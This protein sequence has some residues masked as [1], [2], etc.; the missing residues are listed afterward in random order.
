MPT[1]IAF[2]GQYTDDTG[3]MFFNARYYNPL[4]GR[5]ASAD[6]IVPGAGNPQ[7]LNRYAYTYNNPLRYT[8]STGHCIDPVTGTACAAA[9]FALGTLAVTAIYYAVTPPPPLPHIYNS[10]A[11]YV[12]PQTS[13]TLGE[14]VAYQAW[15]I[16]A[17]H[18]LSQQAE[19]I[20][21]KI[22][23]QED[24]RIRAAR[25]QQGGPPPNFQ[26]PSSNPENDP[27]VLRNLC[28]G[29]VGLALCGGAIIGLV[30]ALSQAETDECK[31]P[32][33]CGGLPDPTAT[34]TPT[35]TPTSTY[36]PT[37]TSTYTSTPTTTPTR[38]PSPTPYSTP[39]RIRYRGHYIDE[40]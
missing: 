1:K 29:K 36:M 9:L 24:Q 12:A 19:K 15:R 38:T 40:E 26:K 7:A 39:E 32:E 28:R 2:T 23:T 34:N 22:A 27:N 31:G 4:T 11:P 18:W 17:A 30:W 13:A 5:F 35:H 37:P 14:T 20:A 21:K 8:D 25:K 33:S 10:P 16:T 6:R 3:L